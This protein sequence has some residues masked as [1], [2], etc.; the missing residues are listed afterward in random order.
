VAG[1]LA[2]SS[3][4]G[5]PW[6]DGCRW[7]TGT[8]AG[9]RWHGRRMALGVAGTRG[10][11]DADAALFDVSPRRGLTAMAER[12]ARWWSG[13]APGGAGERP[14]TTDCVSSGWHAEVAWRLGSNGS[15]GV[16]RPYT[17]WCGTWK[18]AWR[19]ARCGRRQQLDSSQSELGADAV[20]VSLALHRVEEKAKSAQAPGE[21]KEG[22]RGRGLAE[23]QS[24]ADTG[25]GSDPRPELSVCT[26]E[27][28]RAVHEQGKSQTERERER[29]RESEG[30]V[31][32]R[33][34]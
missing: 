10:G 9:P 31:V 5:R 24:R 8:T 13:A 16:Q 11:V 4:G 34:D 33:W 29:E 19:W 26:V 1:E 22:G 32:V 20:G 25:C 2:L 28:G 15:S 7:S 27:R 14:P 12:H 6:Q 30:E 23:R 3:G 17:R 18:P 21:R